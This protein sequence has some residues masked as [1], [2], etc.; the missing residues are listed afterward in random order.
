MDSLDKSVETCRLCKHY[1]PEGRRGGVCEKL[2]V[3]V[4]SAWNACTLASHPFDVSSETIDELSSLLHQ[5]IYEKIHER[6]HSPSEAI[7]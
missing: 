7:A 4:K 5:Q 3:H 6:V 1:N 2:D